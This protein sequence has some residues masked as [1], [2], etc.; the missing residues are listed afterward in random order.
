MTFLVI[1]EPVNGPETVDFLVDE[2]ADDII[3]NLAVFH[4][5]KLLNDFDAKICLTEE[6]MAK[7]F[8]SWYQ[9]HPTLFN[10]LGVAYEEFLSRFTRPS[11]ATTSDVKVPDP[12][13]DEAKPWDN[14]ILP[15]AVRYFEA[16]FLESFLYPPKFQPYTQSRLNYDNGKNFDIEAGIFSELPRGI[17][18]TTVELLTFFPGY[19]K[20]P[21]FQYRCLSAGWT[22][23]SLKR[24]HN[25]H[26]VRDT[27]LSRKTISDTLLRTF[28]TL[29][30]NW[31]FTMEDYY[32]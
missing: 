1:D 2:E 26:Y 19:L 31:T 7:I 18:L 29:T 8:G 27:G 24:A 12:G 3:L 16:A 13:P 28:T 14:K 15:D 10:P 30:R 11:Q 9:R 22:A 20:D 21:F 25:Q 6:N 5:G 32:K 4:H 17:D 23:S